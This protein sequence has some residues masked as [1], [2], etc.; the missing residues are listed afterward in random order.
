MPGQGKISDQ[1]AFHSSAT[2]A[3]NG[4]VLDVWGYEF[5]VV[6]VQGVTTA[7]LIAEGAIDNTNY[8]TLRLMS[9]GGIDSVDSITADG[10]YVIRV[11]GLRSL[12]VRI[13]SYTAGTITVVG[14]A[15]T[16]DPF[17]I[18]YGLSASRFVKTISLTPTLDT[19]AYAVLD[20]LGG[21]QT[22]TDA[23]RVS[24]GSG[25]IET[26]V[27][28]DK[29]QNKANLDIVFFES[30]PAGTYTNNAAVDVTDADILAICGI[31]EISESDYVE[32]TDNCAVCLRNLGIAF[33]ASG[34]ANLY[35]LIIAR[36][37]PTY[38]VGDLEMHVSILQD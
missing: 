18:G 15:A 4:N 6:Q 1:Y 36:S 28:C 23:A 19:N 3:A 8:K 7:T 12:R 32:F 34:S 25:I 29:S 33:T 26:L 10:I 27:L 31:V 22:L 35:A 5:A 14:W 21:E 17:P 9:V 16:V 13:S 38:A 24:G 37:T 20:S 30:N 2:T 11:G